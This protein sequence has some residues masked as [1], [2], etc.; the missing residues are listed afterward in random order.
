[1]RE[2][3]HQVF[4]NLSAKSIELI[5]AQLEIDKLKVEMSRHQARIEDLRK[6]LPLQGVNFYLM[7]DALG[8][9]L[10]WFCTMSVKT[11]FSKALANIRAQ[12]PELS[13][14]EN[15]FDFDDPS[16][17]FSLM[18]EL[19]RT[20][21]RPR[22]TTTLNQSVLVEGPSEGLEEKEAEVQIPDQEDMA[23]LC[24]L[25]ENLSVEQNEGDQQNAE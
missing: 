7:S 19:G 14:D 8:G 3:Y 17:T 13:V 16:A 11:G 23:R 9:N 20:F 25:V 18:I 2:E 22:T 5:A 4:Q 15:N 1:M 6:D 21:R 12:F 24:T 10:G